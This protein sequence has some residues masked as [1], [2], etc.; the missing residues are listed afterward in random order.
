LKVV[1]AYVHVVGVG[2]VGI[3]YKELKALILVT[4]LSPYSFGIQYKEL[5]EKV[6][7]YNLDEPNAGIQYKEL[8]GPPTG[9]ATGLKPVVRIQYKELKVQ[10][11]S[12]LGDSP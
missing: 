3:Q 9:P 4:C 10:H 11:Y 8:K 2:V 12:E 7:Q 5:K 6:R 1:E